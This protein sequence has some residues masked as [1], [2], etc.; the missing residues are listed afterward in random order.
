MDTSAA[1]HSEGVLLEELGWLRTL[2]RRLLNDP[3]DAEDVVQEAWLKT[4]E[5]VDTF[6]S[7]GRLRAWLTGLVHR[8]ARDTMRARRRR[9]RREEV[10][11]ASARQDAED[12]VERLAALESLLHTVR[13]LDEPLR[14]VV[15][16]RY[17]DGHTTA[18]I[19]AA[20]GIS[21]DLVRK[22]LTRGRNALRR[23]LGVPDEVG[24]GTGR[25]FALGAGA[26]LLVGL[27]CGLWARGRAAAPLQPAPTT[28]E[29]APAVLV[30]PARTFESPAV[31]VP[32][33]AP[34]PAPETV[35][36]A[37]A[38]PQPGPEPAPEAEAP[39]PSDSA[40]ASSALDSAPSTARPAIGTGP[41]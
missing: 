21:E 6:P 41:D 26:L 17:L 22:R 28:V 7:R 10:V 27:A 11:A 2:A 16:L 8:M 36:V 24:E 29:L 4:R 18:E 19:A 13:M 32:G 33:P 38:A 1:T 31:L 37:E 20:L 23:A 30:D 35:P 14:A 25:R 15:L 34:E 39:R 40:P 5:V 3:N 9:E 12:G